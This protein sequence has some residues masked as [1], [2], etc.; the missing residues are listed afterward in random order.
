MATSTNP[1]VVNTICAKSFRYTN[2]ITSGKLQI[3][4]NVVT[5]EDNSRNKLHTEQTLKLEYLYR[6]GSECELNT[7]G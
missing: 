6:V 3:K 7:H 5:D 2:T 1:S 4:I